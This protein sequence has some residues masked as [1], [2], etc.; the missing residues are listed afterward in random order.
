M[1]I[2]NALRIQLTNDNARVPKRMSPGSAGYDLFTCEDVTIPARGIGKLPTGV[3]IG[4][5]PDTYARIAPR[6]GL[7]VRGL[8]VGA[9]VVDSDYTAPISVIM[10][11]HTDTAYSFKSGD[12][13]AQLILEVIR[14]PTILIVP[15]LDKTDRGGGG[16]GSTGL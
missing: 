11:N 6:S 2:A 1:S 12:R 4:I 16:F 5:P 10:Y 7:A 9:G 3:A 13:I 15:A 8:D 14:T